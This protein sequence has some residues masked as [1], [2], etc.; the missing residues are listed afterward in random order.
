MTASSEIIAIQLT[1][2]CCNAASM[3][4]VY[5]KR[6]ISRNNKYRIANALIA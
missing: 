3:N 6:F 5:E 4:R 2:A 1:I